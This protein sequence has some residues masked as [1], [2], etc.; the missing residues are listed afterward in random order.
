[1]ASSSLASARLPTPCWASRWYSFTI[2][3]MSCFTARPSP[4]STFLSL[5]SSSTLSR[6]VSWA[7]TTA[8][9]AEPDWARTASAACAALAHTAVTGPPPPAGGRPPSRGRRSR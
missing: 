2:A 7:S 1:M 8:R 3:V 4:A 5:I 6:I 9:R